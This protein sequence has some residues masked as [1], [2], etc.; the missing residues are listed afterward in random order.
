MRTFALIPY[1][2]SLSVAA[3]LLAGCGALP[4]SLSKGQGDMVLPQDATLV[5]QAGSAKYKVVFSFN[6]GTDG[7]EPQAGLLDVGGTLYGTTYGGGAYGNGTVFS[8]SA[9][10]EEKLLHSFGSG[11]D[12]YEPEGSVIDVNGTLYG[13]TVFGGTAFRGFGSCCGT[14]FSLTRNGTE[15][16][17]HFFGHVNDGWWPHAGLTDVNGMLYGTTANGGGSG[18]G[19]VGCGTVF[20][21]S[22]TGK[23]KVL[24]SFGE[25]ADGQLPYASL[26]AVNGKLYGTTAF[27]GAGDA[28][29]VFSIS[30]TGKEKVLFSFDGTDGARSV[31]NLIDV[32]DT[33]YGTTSFGGTGSECSSSCGT[34]FSVSTSGK[35]K[36]VLSFTGADGAFPEAGLVYLNGALYGTTSGGARQSRRCLRSGC[37]TL[38]SVTPTGNEVV[39]HA[40]GRDSDGYY[41]ISALIDVSGTLYG[42]TSR[43][44]A[45]KHGPG[46]VFALTP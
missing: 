43:G 31:A 37:G 11:N 33:L 45:H 6:G 23:E 46:T 15:K 12:G 7:A 13:T 42:T 34:V 20:S 35:E 3:A 21:I 40:F 36:V 14:V 28:G 18:C 2:L 5:P 4:L 10:G 38:F 39:L 27:G 44:G 22:T 26:I 32:N 25:G 41:P 29:T 8:I 9:S 16:I 1:A 24:H 17:L 19:G 30:T